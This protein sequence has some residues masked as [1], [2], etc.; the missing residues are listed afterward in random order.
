MRS[1]KALTAVSVAKLTKPG[2]Y[3]V[4]NGAYLQISQ[5]GT[6]AWLFRYR[7]NG[8]SHQ[9]GLGP[10]ELISLAEA[11]DKAREARRALL[12]GDD[13]LTAKRQRRAQGRLQAASGVT[14][15]QAAERMM[16]S[17]GAAWKNFKHRQQWGNT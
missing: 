4:G 7:R 17:H 11:R 6:K 15:K 2:R 12:D 9:M 14:F 13:P 5:W 8:K 10:C 16:A 1:A 3:A